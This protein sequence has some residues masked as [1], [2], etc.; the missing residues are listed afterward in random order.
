[1]VEEGTGLA[2]DLAHQTLTATV[3]DV[4]RKFK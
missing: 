3:E 1:V 2:D 4:V